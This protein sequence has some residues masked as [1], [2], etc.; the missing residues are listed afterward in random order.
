MGL[1][2]AIDYTLL[3]VQQIPQQIADGSVATML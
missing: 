1:A 2:L 3:L